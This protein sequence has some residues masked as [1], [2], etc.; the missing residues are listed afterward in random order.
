MKTKQ[1]L[2]LGSA[3]C[4]L[5]L[6]AMEPIVIKATDYTK[7]RLFSY[8]P[9]PGDIPQRV[10]SGG[11]L[12]GW[13]KSKKKNPGT[14]GEYLF[15]FSVP[16]DGWYEI[17][18][19]PE[20]INIAQVEFTL[21]GK[22]YLYPTNT[23][24][25][26]KW[27]G[28]EKYNNA[29]VLG[30]F[31]LKKGTH[32]LKAEKRQWPHS[33]PKI[34]EFIIKPSPQEN[35][36]R[37]SLTDA[38]GNEITAA[39]GEKIRFSA[40]YSALKKET[41]LY[42]VFTD[43]KTKKE[44]FAYPVSL[45]ASDGSKTAAFSVP[46]DTEGIFR[47]SF[48]LGKR[49][50]PWSV[51]PEHDLVVIDPTPLKES[52]APVRKTLLEEIDCVK[53]APDFARGN[54]QVK[55]NLCG[56]FREVSGKSGWDKA[57]AANPEWIA[58]RAVLPEA[59]VLY[60]IEF[61]YPDDTR[62]ANQFTL[63][64]QNNGTYPATVGTNSGGEFRIS[65]KMQ[66]ASLVTRPTDCDIRLQIMSGG[67]GLRAAVSKIRIYR[68]EA[69]NLPPLF[70]SRKGNRQY[71]YYY[72]E[73]P[74]MI[75][76]VTGVDVKKASPKVI[77]RGINW[78]CALN[79]Y[80]GSSEQF[81]T[82]S[83]YGGGLYPSKYRPD[84]WT[85]PF[86]KDFVKKFILTAMKYRQSAVFDFHSALSDFKEDEKVLFNPENRLVN[87]SGMTNYFNLNKYLVNP[88][89]PET[90]KW[91]LAM[92]REFV[93]RYQ[94]FPS[95][96]GIRLRQMEW[97]HSGWISFTSLNWGYDDYT[98]G[99]FEKETGIRV[100]TLHKDQRRFGERYAYL[101][102]NHYD[103]WVHWRAEKITGLYTEV[104]NMIRA[105]RPDLKLYCNIPEFTSPMEA[106]IDVESLQRNGI[107]TVRTT[108]TGRPPQPGRAEKARITSLKAFEAKPEPA[109]MERGIANWQF[110]YEG[111]QRI[112]RPSELGYRL[113]KNQKD[114]VYY[115]SSA[116]PAGR[117]E[118]EFWAL[119]VAR[120]DISVVTGGSIGYGVG[121]PVMREF[122]N[123]F[124]RL[125]SVAFD[126]ILKDPV[127]VRRYKEYFYAVNS[128]PVP[129][130]VQ[131]RLKSRFFGKASAKRLADGSEFD[132]SDFELKPYQLLAFSTDTAPESAKV[133]VP[134]SY[135]KTV[136][137]QVKQLAVAVKNSP[138]LK[139]LSG[140][141]STAFDRGEYCTVRLL[142]EIN[143]P[144]MAKNGVVIS[145]LR[146]DGE[147][148]IPEDAL[149]QT[150]SPVKRIPAKE[151]FPEWNSGTFLTGTSVLFR[152]DVPANGT[153]RL[154]VAYLGGDRYG[155]ILVYADSRPIGSLGNEGGSAYA[156]TGELKDSFVLKKGK[157]NLE[158][159]SGSQKPVAILYMKLEP[160]FSP[161]FARY[162]RKSAAYF[163]KGGHKALTAAMAKKEPAETN[164][165]FSGSFWQ[166][167]LQHKNP[168]N[169][170]L[171]LGG[172]G[173]GYTT[174]LLTYLHSPVSQTVQISIGADYFWKIWCRGALVQDTSNQNG[175]AAV[176][177]AAHYFVN[178]KPGWNEI[179]LK[180]GSGTADNCAWFSVNNPGNLKFSANGPH[181]SK[182]KQET[183]KGKCLLNLDLKQKPSPGFCGK[184]FLSLDGVVWKNGI[185]VLPISNTKGEF[186]VL[187]P[188]RGG[189]KFLMQADMCASE[190]E[191]K[192]LLRMDWQTGEK[193]FG[194][195]E[196]KI[197]LPT[198]KGDF[199]IT[200]IS[201]KDAEYVILSINGGSPANPIRIHQIKFYEL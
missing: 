57:T 112:A 197:N 43:A 155:K 95:F 82:I 70:G 143:A 194:K 101:T 50:L 24:M 2:F 142:L 99:Q 162:F 141:V 38:Y 174:Y 10:K 195:S 37:V 184:A 156:A 64:S 163:T 31:F 16:D 34:T 125:P 114:R 65:G 35:R 131:I 161:V 139:E 6:S 51:A 147:L 145:S 165:D 56:A 81:Y 169:H 128:L 122:M 175:G 118:L 134:E 79:A 178:L 110:Y 4:F 120:R 136:A 164:R 115:C 55:Q 177:D 144:L 182:R 17:S 61:D 157:T 23:L 152:P 140:K 168:E 133:I 196:K 199:S 201:P 117:N 159:R 25:G 45:P 40:E 66:T 100:H 91:R 27:A 60:Q 108:N 14:A 135:V 166:M 151:I 86:E 130:K 189:K 73:A 92:L 138:S 67:M 126:T 28:G 36:M 85:L 183:V 173:V 52:A 21:D 104:L 41:S 127:A 171:P 121:N 3:I 103:R 59:Q 111:G 190:T 109:G 12:A 32:S 44:T 153:Y 68:I 74:S 20:N 148:E 83:I 124:L 46:C 191:A 119:G 160:V 75:R 48:R 54:H 102:R 170:I 71:Q 94:K 158:F 87:N 9:D 113:G 181:T 47:I 13:E 185:L 192:V 106:G 149:T 96:T 89:H 150:P 137:G 180:I 172:A 76:I 29:S 72:E 1:L 132:V 123:E 176:P 105:I 186:G 107:I 97:Q 88:I 33:F 22:T 8:Q 193:F 167:P 7:A 42:A 188:V 80:M 5:P 30:N 63:R 200:G 19:G 116:W 84:M 198:D 49:T 39:K 90:R 58:Y 53:R 62:R 26:V 11:N 98:I 129:V 187:F 154:K 15:S 78:Y 69:E 146:E 93:E 179:M 77:L 18:A